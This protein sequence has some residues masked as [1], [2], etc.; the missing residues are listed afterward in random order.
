MLGLWPLLAAL[1]YI[2]VIRPRHNLSLGYVYQS[3]AK[4]LARIV[5]SGFGGG[6]ARRYCNADVP[7]FPL[8]CNG[9]AMQDR[10]GIDPLVI[11]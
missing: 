7:A 8:G 6:L 3:R 2:L 9:G 4:S 11:S 10:R 1:A 5:I